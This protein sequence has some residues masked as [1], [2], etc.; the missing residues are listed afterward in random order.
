M[1]LDENAAAENRYK[2]RGQLLQEEKMRNKLSKIIPN[3]KAV[4]FALCEGQT[5]NNG[6]AT[7]TT[8][9]ETPEAAIQYLHEKRALCLTQS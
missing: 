6:G 9:G 3:I 4:I 5:N 8:F 7:F 2:N 1:V